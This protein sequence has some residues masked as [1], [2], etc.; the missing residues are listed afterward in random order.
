MKKLTVMVS[1]VL[2]WIGSAQW[3]AAQSK[4]NVILIMTD[5]QRGDAQYQ[6]IIKQMKRE[7][8]QLRQHVGDTD[9]SS[10]RMHDIL[11]GEGV[12]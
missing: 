7:M 10:Q 1:A 12:E 4:P 11:R 2:A 3:A 6:G 8:M 5:Q 9:A